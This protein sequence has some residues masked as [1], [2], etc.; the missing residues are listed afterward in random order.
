MMRGN[1]AQRGER[2]MGEDAADELI[3]DWRDALNEQPGPGTGLA[4]RIKRDLDGS[5]GVTADDAFEAVTQLFCD[6][7]RYRVYTVDEGRATFLS[8]PA[9]NQ[10]VKAC[11]EAFAEWWDYKYPRPKTKEDNPDP[12]YWLKFDCDGSRAVQKNTNHEG[13]TPYATM[14][15]YEALWTSESIRFE[16]GYC[17][18]KTKNLSI[19][20][21]NPRFNINYRNE[22]C[23]IRA[24]GDTM[25][26]VLTTLEQVT[27]LK[28]TK[29]MKKKGVGETWKDF[30][31]SELRPQV[32]LFCYLTHTM[33]NFIPCAVGFNGGRYAS[34]Q[35]YWDLTLMCI[36]AWYLDGQNQAPAILANDPLDAG[37]LTK[38]H[39]WLDAFGYGSSGWKAFIEKNYLQD[40]VQDD[41]Y[42][43]IPLFHYEN[44]KK[45][46]GNL[47][48]EGHCFGGVLPK[49]NTEIRECLLNM[50]ACIIARGLRMR[51]QLLKDDKSKD[52]WPLFC[53]DP[54]PEK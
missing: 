29:A 23:D 41:T 49:G 52:A 24:S 30:V 31:S 17:Q 40:W 19:R 35:D 9:D 20:R 36:R 45:K 1:M 33:G 18:G 42:E 44:D 21:F 3:K 6:F 47:V 10:T 4:E 37:V 25:N 53:N 2:A 54:Y 12:H 14:R 13:Y 34:T 28:T 11:E 26:G 46:R 38:C 27:K 51:K 39:A 8:N 15:L 43:V 50:N 48:G 5:N 22:S 32:G 7:K 16:S